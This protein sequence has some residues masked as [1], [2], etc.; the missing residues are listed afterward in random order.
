MILYFNRSTGEI[1]VG[2]DYRDWAE[3]EKLIAKRDPKKWERINPNGFL[4][5][6]AISEGHLD[7]TTIPD[8]KI[9]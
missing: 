6:K 3:L 4:Y 1:L 5:C 8:P 9:L 2:T 7:V